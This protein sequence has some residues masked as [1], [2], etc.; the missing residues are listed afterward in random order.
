M[1]YL[2]V[3]M[4]FLMSV[5]LFGQEG[6]HKRKD[7]IKALKIGFIT[8]KLDLTPE[9]SEKFWPI[10]NQHEKE[11]ETLRTQY[12]PRDQSEEL[13]EEEALALIDKR[14]AFEEKMLILNKNYINDLK[15]VLSGKQILTL[16]NVD[17][18]IKRKMLKSMKDRRGDRNMEK[19]K[20]KK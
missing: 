9:T 6:T 17:R 18:E 15:T 13:G 8:E 14:I 10:Y 2:I 4:F 1:K 16:L 20:K 7:Q 3:G 11:V 19:R 5:S 12:A